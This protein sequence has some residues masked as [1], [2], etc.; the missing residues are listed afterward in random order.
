MRP[1]SSFSYR[2]AAERSPRRLCN[3][4]II[5]RGL[6]LSIVGYDVVNVAECSVFYVVL[7][8][9]TLVVVVNDVNV[10]KCN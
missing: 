5:L 2:E 4:K 1:A 7:E 9:N 6:S 8:K 3:L 10:G